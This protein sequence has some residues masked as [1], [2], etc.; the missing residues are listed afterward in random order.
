[1]PDEWKQTTITVD[2]PKTPLKTAIKAGES[3]PGVHL[4]QRESLQRK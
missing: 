4:E 3:I 2:I 1:V